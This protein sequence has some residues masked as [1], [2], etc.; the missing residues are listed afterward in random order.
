MFG[1]TGIA[2][3]I[4]NHG[5]KKQ[6]RTIYSYD[7][8]TKYGVVDTPRENRDEEQ[9]TAQE[10]VQGNKGPTDTDPAFSR[11]LA[12]QFLRMTAFGAGGRLFTYVLTLD[13]EWRF[14][15][16]GEEFAVQML[17]KHSMHADLA[18]EVAFAGEFFVRPVVDE[19]GGGFE[20]ARKVED[21][22]IVQEAQEK[23]RKKQEK[24]SKGEKDDAGGGGDPD[25]PTS[26]ADKDAAAGRASPHMRTLAG[27]DDYAIAEDEDPAR[28]ELV[29]DNSSG[30]YRPPSERLPT[31]RAWLAAPGCLGALGRV[32]CVDGFDPVLK[33]AK[34]ARSAARKEKKGV[35]DGER[36]AMPRRGSSVSSIGSGVIGRGR[37]SVSSGE[38]KRALREQEGQSQEAD[39][40]P[41]ANGDEHAPEVAEGQKPESGETRQEEGETT[42][43]GANGDVQQAQVANGAAH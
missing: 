41:H 14:T 35:K 40:S 37:R 26:D 11:A 43:S 32:T 10:G 21:G 16:T 9:G 34:L 25:K 5:L 6:Y 28:F 2:G 19:P 18:K 31:L 38:I 39:A 23:E 36:V 27:A 24:E 12:L 29:L 33:Q 7:A 4:L 3:R 42:S 13:G 17:S 20:S 15:E 30:T 1:D 8:N 22:S